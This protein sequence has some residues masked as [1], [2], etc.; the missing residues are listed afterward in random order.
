LIPVA[1]E[2]TDDGELVEE[3]QRLGVESGSD[4][5]VLSYEYSHVLTSALRNPIGRDAV[6]IAAAVSPAASWISVNSRRIVF[7]SLQ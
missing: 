4:S 6:W 3:C 2:A 5:G 7:G 1:I